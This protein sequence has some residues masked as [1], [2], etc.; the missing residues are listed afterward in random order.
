MSAILCSD[1]SYYAGLSPDE[2]APMYMAELA[3]ETT[4]TWNNGFSNW[5]DT[6]MNN[7]WLMVTATGIYHRGT[8][9]TCLQRRRRKPDRR[10]QDRRHMVLD[11]H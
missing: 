9:W 8:S 11:L 2:N 6:A 3:T 7:N 4:T 1:G 10:Y 5:I